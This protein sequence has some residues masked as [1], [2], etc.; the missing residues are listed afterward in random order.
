VKVTDLVRDTA[1]VP[2][3]KKNA[4]LVEDADRQ[5]RR[6]FVLARAHAQLAANPVWKGA[7]VDEIHPQHVAA[8]RAAIA[9]DLQQAGSRVQVV[10]VK[11]ADPAQ[12]ALVAIDDAHVDAKGRFRKRYQA[13]LGMTQQQIRDVAIVSSAWSTA[14]ANPG[15][16]IADLHSLVSRRLWM[17]ERMLWHIGRVGS[18]EWTIASDGA[19]RD[20][21][22]RMFEYPRLPIDAINTPFPGMCN[23]PDGS[24]DC[25]NPGPMAGWR[26]ES[27]QFQTARRV[28][29][30]ADVLWK[31]ADPTKDIPQYFIKGGANDPAN[32]VFNLFERFDDFRHRNLLMCDHVIQTLHLESLVRVV[33]KREGNKTWFK[34][35][36]DQKPEGWLR[37]Q[38]PNLWHYGDVFLVGR[39]EPAFF[40]RKE[41]D[42]NQLELGDHVIVVNHPAYDMAREI[43]DVWNIENALVVTT[44][45]RLLLQGHGTDPLPF[46]SSRKMKLKSGKERPETSMRLFMINLFNKKLRFLRDL[47]IRENA[48]PAPREVINDF[49]SAGAFLVQRADV[50][51]YSGFDI[52]AYTPVA[53]KLARWWMAWRVSDNHKREMDIA[54]DPD[55]ARWVWKYQKV[56]L[57][58]RDPSEVWGLFPLWEERQG[59][60]GSSRDASGKIKW[61]QAVVVSQETTPGWS[62]YYPKNVKPE[63]ARGQ[64]LAVRRPKIS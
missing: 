57:Y 58:K 25:A 34:T 56:E 40:E 28:N 19:W 33:S 41:I 14:E 44:F 3:R 51:P 39:N 31:R 11:M 54:T 15:M 4:T 20:T 5:A 60:A 35:L 63:D 52:N 13:Q 23:P 36:V 50:G 43:V 61:L 18:R 46:S 1:L 29:P 49:D 26:R 8:L 53:A 12:T 24:Q 2:A 42:A 6:R 16:E 55:W 17:V 22:E 47:A 9:N 64:Q 10:R 21:W 59:N 62:W 30:F 37:I 45:P 48:K 38:P 27:V 7:D 32:A